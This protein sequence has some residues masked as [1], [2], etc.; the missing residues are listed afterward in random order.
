MST[1]NPNP[2]ASRNRKPQGGTFYNLQMVIIIA[3]VVA[4]LFTAWTPASLI[5]GNLSE[6]FS[7]IMAVRSTPAAGLPTPTARAPP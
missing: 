3:F 2:Q 5:P 6:Q 1:I 7:Q 4:T